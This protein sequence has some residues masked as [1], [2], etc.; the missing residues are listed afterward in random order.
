MMKKIK[1]M[2]GVKS[3]LEETP[4]SLEEFNRQVI[5]TSAKSLARWVAFGELDINGRLDFM[6]IHNSYAIEVKNFNRETEMITALIASGGP[7]RKWSVHVPNIVD[8]Q[9]Y[10]VVNIDAKKREPLTTTAEKVVKEFSR[11]R[12]H[13]YHT[14]VVDELALIS[15]TNLE[16]A[17]QFCEMF[18]Q[19]GRACGHDYSKIT[20]GMIE[21]LLIFIQE[22]E[23]DLDTHAQWSILVG[24]FGNQEPKISK[25]L[26]ILLQDRRPE[27][28]TDYIRFCSHRLNL[29]SSIITWRLTLFFAYLEYFQTTRKK[30]FDSRFEKWHSGPT[31]PE[32]YGHTKIVAAQVGHHKPAPLM[33]VEHDDA[34]FVLT[35][36]KNEFGL[37]AFDF[38]PIS[39]TA[40]YFDKHYPLL[41]NIIDRIL[42][43]I[44]S[45]GSDKL[46]YLINQYEP[47]NQPDNWWVKSETK[48]AVKLSDKELLDFPVLEEFLQKVKKG[49]G[50]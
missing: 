38:V 22:H 28:I 36:E 37:N 40:E 9:C 48:N 25:N 44:E 5:F 45:F 41:R 16:V 29:P 6:M 4:L 10:F 30:L 47:Y 7:K 50:D 42:P 43:Q 20:H 49:S 12:N 15:T 17:N 21:P 33:S 32:V 31:L 2:L 1:N 19:L 18:A 46:M 24:E 23:Q 27:A 35:G 3:I 14:G 8:E 13:H 26:A 34:T 11:F 39:E